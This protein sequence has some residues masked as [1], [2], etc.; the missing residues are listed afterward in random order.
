MSSMVN[1]T[2][3]IFYKLYIYILDH[4]DYNNCDFEPSLLSMERSLSSE[5]KEELAHS[6]KKVKDVSH[7]GFCEGHSSGLASPNHAE[8]LWN[9][10]AS[11][12]DKLLGEISGAFS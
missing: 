8:G 1:S 12:R 10:N 6:K 5:E 11:F 7:A 9:P 4:K 3:L 2:L